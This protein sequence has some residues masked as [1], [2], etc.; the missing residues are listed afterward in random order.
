MPL[1]VSLLVINCLQFTNLNTFFAEESD[2]GE[3]S[4]Y[5][6]KLMN[7]DSEY[8][9]I[10]ET[11]YNVTI[12]MPSAKFSKICRDL[13]QLSDSVTITC[14]KSG[15]QFSAEGDLGTGSITLQQTSNIDKPEENITISMQESITQSF[16]LKYLNHFT[17]A[18]PLSSQVILSLSPDVPLVVEYKINDTDSEEATNVDVG[19]IRYYL[20]PK[21]DDQNE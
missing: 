9:G 18:A 17:K 14:T 5:E 15:I 1:R 2:S 19:H 11:S 13:T 8:L 12:T 7:L 16:A 4:E 6:I 21:I 3:V 10:P 20:A